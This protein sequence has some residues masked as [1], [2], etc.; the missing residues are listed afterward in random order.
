MSARTGRD[1]PG[2]RGDLEGLRGLAVVL[3]LLFHAS[4]PG[5]PG[6]YVG[7][8]LFF[9][10]SGFL[11]TGLLLR[12][13]T[14]TGRIGLHA[15]FAGRARRILPAAC[16]VLVG[17]A[18]AAWWVLP[19]LR[20]RD[21]MIDVLASALQVANL[22]FI[23]Q[24]TDY[25]AAASAPSP[26]LHYWSLAVE[27]Q[28]YVVLPLLL[29]LTGVLAA[30]TR[31][32]PLPAAVW[33][34]VVAT[35]ASFV[36]SLVLTASDPA[37]AYMSPLTRAWQFGVGGLLAAALLGRPDGAAPLSHASLAP[38]RG[39]RGLRGLRRASWTLVGWAGCA[40]IGWS[41][42]VCDEA[43]A[44]PGLA[45]LLPTLGTVAILAAPADVRVV[46][47]TVGHV[48]TLAPVRFVGRLSFAW[49]LVHW[50]VLVLADA[51]WGPLGWPQR[52]VLTLGAG[53]LAWLVLRC[54]EAPLRHSPAVVLRPSASY[55]VGFT[56]VV[57]ALTASLGAGSAVYGALA[58]EDV[59]A[60][61]VALDEIFDPASLARTGGPVSPGLTRA[62]LDAPPAE[63]PCLGSLSLSA[64]DWPDECVVGPPG[65]PEVVLF[66][67]SKA[68]QWSGALRDIAL[69]Q[70]WHLTIV[71]KGGCTPSALPQALLEESQHCES[72]RDAQVAR[73]AAHADVVILGSSAA[74]FLDEQA[75]D[76]RLDAWRSTFDRFAEHDVP[77]VYLRDTPTPVFDVPS[78]VSGAIDDWDECAFA[79]A[80]GLPPDPLLVDV[81]LGDLP[82]VEAVDVSGVLCSTERCPA[83]LGGLLLYRDGSHLT[84]TAAG[85][86]RPELE[87][88]LLATSALGG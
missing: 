69:D 57:L 24:E 22:R 74:Y 26:V 13:L 50:P 9:V 30:R 28:F 10:V 60:A 66:G 38:A 6:G 70:G 14:S 54:V 16:V 40:A 47:G 44:F 64:T 86:L 11:I 77:V 42:V 71:T 45:A 36:V 82:G 25:M 19:P 62:A 33:V 39:R 76:L 55:S 87:R 78:C 43:T 31:R 85:V 56:G 84:A 21:T 35:V 41:T 49:Y 65:G 17:T 23:A 81:A 5:V 59:A 3:V 52:V 27:E 8:D 73:I 75:A 53:G 58:D 67:D 15:F 83:V 20:A 61:D 63:T 18:V 72:W 88:A 4:V 68:F 80:E 7:V 29:A 79:R 2:F 1:R 46:P 37:V 34:L 48:L 12:E 51:A 32:R